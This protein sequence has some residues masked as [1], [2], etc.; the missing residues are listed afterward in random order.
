MPEIIFSAKPSQV[1]ILESTENKARHEKTEFHQELLG[2]RDVSIRTLENIDKKSHDFFNSKEHEIS[3]FDKEY[4]DIKLLVSGNG[5]CENVKIFKS[6]LEVKVP[7]YVSKNILSMNGTFPHSEMHALEGMISKSHS[8]E[9]EILPYVELN[10][11]EV[12]HGLSTGSSELRDL[13]DFRLKRNPNIKE[14]V[15]PVLSNKDHWYAVH[16]EIDKGRN[17]I[18]TTIINTTN[19]AKV[20]ESHEEILDGYKQVQSLLHAVFEKSEVLS[21]V[22]VGDFQFCQSLQYG[23]MGCGITT[24]LNSQA[25]LSGEM[26]VDSLKFTKES[27]RTKDQVLEMSSVNIFSDGEK[28]VFQNE[29]ADLAKSALEMMGAI[30]ARM[31]TQENYERDD[32]ESDMNNFFE[33]N[34]ET[35]QVEYVIDTPPC[36]IE[37]KS[38]RS[39]LALESIR[40]ADLALNY[41]D[42]AEKRDVLLREMYEVTQARTL[43]SQDRFEFKS[44]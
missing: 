39:N 32:L 24:S 10:S 37:D 2:K 18:R 5:R 17:Q 28:Y 13:I 44:Q 3:Y 41:L 25:L 19:E 12:K 36:L 11:N 20:K 31:L 30:P 26:K 33:G 34:L 14:M 21:S 7:E 42:R 38:Q 27:F 22:E 29:K 23:N 43:K 6:G 15:I 9:N 40:R 35:K 4:G 8:K 1:S 16:V